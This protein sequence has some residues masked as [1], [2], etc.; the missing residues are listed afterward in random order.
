MRQTWVFWVCVLC[1]AAFPLNADDL[2]HEGSVSA[3]AEGRE[4]VLE[5]Q[6]G[7]ETTVTPSA[8]DERP[9][10]DLA[11]LWDSRA[12]AARRPLST[13]RRPAIEYRRVPL[14]TPG[15]G[16]A[17]PEIDHALDG[18]QAT[19]IASGDFDGDGAIDLV[20]GRSGIE[21]H[22]LTLHRGLPDY[23][24]FSSATRPA[25][26][27]FSPTL[28]VAG[29]FDND[30]RQ[31]LIASATGQASFFLFTG[32]AR[33]GLQPVREYSVAG[34][35]TAMA[36][37]D[38]D[39]ADGLIDLVVGV[40]GPEGPAALLYAGPE[41]ALLGEPHS[42]RMGTSIRSIVAT[43]VDDDSYVDLAVVAGDELW[44]RRGGRSSRAGDTPPAELERI[45]VWS[46]PRSV[47]PGLHALRVGSA[48]GLAVLDG[49]DSV[50]VIGLDGEP[51]GPAT[52]AWRGVVET[53]ELAAPP[54]QTTLLPVRLNRD[55]LTDYIGL[56]H[57]EVF[58]AVSSIASTIVVTS[59]SDSAVAGD[60]ACT[61]REAILN[62]NADS[63]TTAGDCA[64]GSGTDLIGFNIAG[65]GASA[66][67]AIATALPAI[68]DPVT[69]DGPT[70][71]C[72]SGPC[73]ELDGTTAVSANGLELSAGASVVRGLVIR[74]FDQYG[75]LID[76][77][78]NF[79]EA[80]YA[81]T[82]L[83]GNVARGNQIG[84]AVLGADNVIGGT[85]LGSG[86]ILSGNDLFGVILFS[87]FAVRNEVLG[88]WIGTIF[89]GGAGL[90]N[91]I[92]GVQVYNGASDNTIGGTA[93]GS[94]NII[95]GNTNYGVLVGLGSDRNEVLGNLIGTDKSGALAL[96]NRSGVVIR[97]SSLNIVGGTA[98]GA[99]NVLSGNTEAGVFVDGTGE[100][101]EI[102]GNFIGTRS[103]GSAA[104][105][106][107]LGG[108]AVQTSTSNTIGGPTPSARNVISGN[109][110]YGILLIGSANGN[111]VQGNFIGLDPS[112]AAALG[113][114]TNGIEIDD[115]SDNTIGGD[116]P[117]AGNVISGNGLDGVFL[118]D[119]TCTANTVSG[120]IIGLDPS[121]TFALPN[122]DEGVQILDGAHQNTI[123]GTTPGA[124]NVISGNVGEGIT[125]LGAGSDENKILGNYIGTDIT[126]SVALGN[127]L[128]GIRLESIVLTEIAGNLISGNVRFGIFSFTNATQGRFH[129][130]FI[131]TDASGTASVGN[132]LS[133]IVI[134]QS[135][136]NDIGGTAPGDGNLISG[137][138]EAGIIIAFSQSTGNKV[139]GNL[140]GTDVSGTLPLSN[141]LQGVQ[142]KSATGN[143]IG[144][145]TAEARNVISSNLQS[146]VFLN[147]DTTATSGNSVEGNFIGVDVNGSPLLGNRLDGVFVD[148]GA[149]DNNIGGTTP[150]TGNVIAGNGEHGVA[151][152]DGA[153]RIGILGNSIF[154][155][156]LAGIDLN[157]DGITPNDA[158]DG[159]T[160][161]N[162]LQNFPDLASASAS[163]A[164][165]TVS[166]NLSSASGSTY[167]VEFF[168]SAACHGLGNGEGARFLGFTDVTTD[169]T[170]NQAFA[171]VLPAA[172][173]D[174]E[175]VTATATD[176]LNNTSEFS[177]CIVA[178]CATIGVFGQQITAPDADTLSWPNPADVR[179]VK[180]PLSSVSSY[181]VTGSGVLAGESSLDLTAD[182]P[183][184][185]IGVYYLVKPYGCGSWQTLSGA[186][187]G[188]DSTLP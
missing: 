130:N 35:V 47:L 134:N 9:A 126:G 88:N 110:G 60:G 181:A 158:G 51:H 20:V 68:T 133:G 43:R 78:G 61:L 29:D 176:S 132:L 154:A 143:G 82:N 18:T 168:A 77:D 141:Q 139:Q 138:G 186:E 66:A 172:V 24:G 161:G 121:G 160:G 96:A 49:N 183:G 119:P 23:A 122:A 81:G 52:E 179:F 164:G 166:G 15:G 12:R 147:F 116:T 113:N 142:I 125:I 99:A 109:T 120:N 146:G 86:N 33:S 48:S 102:L 145:L 45:P 175:V 54:R 107:G 72:P 162:E 79:V 92:D 156:T 74:D 2:R 180:G 129:G 64:A 28:L 7:V 112:G 114:G 36:A 104:L 169:G 184:P 11:G 26:V 151:V 124:R 53:L 127:Q 118:D 70:Q 58:E 42:T 84:V 188:R 148:P 10:A 136:S 131:G 8:H 93:S 40:D 152:P 39:R 117:G 90:A 27:A 87:Q 73:I 69:V 115:A 100:Q 163:P 14:R 155:N 157:L 44:V 108:I 85:S 57:G 98:A 34:A 177:A 135:P 62:S 105:A 171:A 67:I 97:D 17:D 46:D 55:A 149:V 94:H 25:R 41:G 144:G 140:I 56:E 50:T 91:G 101:N 3:T 4:T 95:S 19:A 150:G 187:P 71:G 153:S 75:I 1:C 123:G 178:S 22:F 80:C 182:V 106:N 174:A 32:D 159:D 137:N 170:G 38:V 128:N 65:G 111:S 89:G 165:V 13:L 5:N 37:G 6:A 76:S 185:S 103:G 21:G 167:R 83:N 63:D 30:G 59:T 31:D 16:P 173:D